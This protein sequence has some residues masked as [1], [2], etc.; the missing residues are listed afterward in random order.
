MSEVIETLRR[1]HINLAELLR[2]LDTQMAVFENGG[3]P[4]YELLAGIVDYC[5]NYPDLHHHP[6]ED[7]VLK[8]MREVAPEA[9]KKVGDLDALHRELGDLTRRL[10][11]ALHQILN[12][13]EVDRE[14]VVK[15][16]KDFIEAY[17]AHINAEELYFFPAAEMALSDSDWEDVERGIADLDDPLFGTAVA[18]EYKQLHETIMRWSNMT[19]AGA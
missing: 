6:M 11:A 4:D 5:L 17:R 7:E 9:A 13:A 2:V 12:E 19:P 18:K 10:S 15:L 8:K 1:D 14:A 16:A 3:R